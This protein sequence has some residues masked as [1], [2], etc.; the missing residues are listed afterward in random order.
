MGTE[1]LESSKVIS[2][3][4]KARVNQERA[5]LQRLLAEDIVLTTYQWCETN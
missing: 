1:E 2:E 3:R 4:Y 5:T